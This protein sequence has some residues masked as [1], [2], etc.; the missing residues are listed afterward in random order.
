MPHLFVSCRQLCLDWCGRLCYLASSRQGRPSQGTTV[1]DWRLHWK[2]EPRLASAC[3]ARPGLPR[4][5]LP[6]R[7]RRAYGQLAAA[8]FSRGTTSGESAGT[9]SSGTAGGD[10]ATSSAEGGMAE[11]SA[12]PEED[13][14]VEGEATGV[15]RCVCRS[16]ASSLLRRSA[17]EGCPPCLGGVHPVPSRMSASVRSKS[18][19]R[20]GGAGAT[21]WRGSAT[22]RDVPPTALMENRASLPNEMTVRSSREECCFHLW[23]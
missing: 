5:T 21:C 13:C 22:P 3:L 9:S 7:C 16:W 15:V 6:H 8:A 14:P 11:L 23:K 17:F 18:T 19:Q 2:S 20:L 10:S 4:V 1:A 12:P